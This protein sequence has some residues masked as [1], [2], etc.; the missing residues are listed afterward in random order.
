MKREGKEI[1]ASLGVSE[2][3]DQE[4]RSDT[5]F[6]TGGEGST[7]V[8][9]DA[10]ERKETTTVL[11][12]AFPLEEGDEGSDSLWANAKRENGL[13]LRKKGVREGVPPI[14]RKRKR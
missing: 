11:G 8:S 13:A 6:R 4:R 1:L 5:T 2:V 9:T 14:I 3:I 12:G 7:E 10:A